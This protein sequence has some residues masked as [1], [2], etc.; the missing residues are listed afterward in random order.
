M[1]RSSLVYLTLSVTGMAA[2]LA[3]QRPDSVVTMS[4]VPGVVHR[5]LL[6]GEGPWSVNVVEVDL[7]QPGISIRAG[8]AD[9]RLRG[10]ETVSAMVRRKTTDT[11]TIVAAINA[12]FFNLKTGEDENNQVIEG[13]IW[14]GVQVADAPA[15]TGRHIHTQLGIAGNGR[16]IMD[17]FVFRGVVLRLRG[18]RL[19][20]DAINYRAN[21][22]S[23][24]L[25]TARFGATT[26]WDS[27]GTSVDIRLRPVTSRGD[28]SVY[29]VVSFPMAGGTASLSDGPVLSLPVTLDTSRDVPRP[30]EMIRI[31]TN[32]LPAP[33]GLRTVVGGW[34]RLVVHGQSIADSVD[35]L[36]GTFKSF[37]VTRHPRTGV[38]VSRDSTTL[39]LITVDGRQESSSGMS[40]VE[41]ANLM[42]KL[43]VYEGLNLDGGGS[44]TMVINGKVVNTPSDK[45]GGHTVERTVGNALLVVQ[46]RHE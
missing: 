33:L 45:E 14:K 24:V 12:D 6:I 31:Q 7:R 11:A 38:G 32:L 40:L 26:P 37:S 35:R 5:H 10:R 34:P 25:Y 44:T 46:S 21:A 1:R 43:G 3:G 19:Q 41:F 39:Y 42:L 2:P 27:V 23:I 9:D 30:G 29:Q 8:H 17:P 13:E 36:E 28:T 20:L 18:Q 16:P 15:D 22:Y 4:V